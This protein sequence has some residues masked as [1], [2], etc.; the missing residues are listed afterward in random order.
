MRPNIAPRSDGLTIDVIKHVKENISPPITSLTNNIL[1]TGI[2]PKKFKIAQIQPVKKSGDKTKAENYRSIS[3]IS[4]IAK[5]IKTIIKNRI[6]S[7]LSK[8]NPY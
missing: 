3:V 1:Q 4:G 8:F 7:F 5:I 2:F 6:R